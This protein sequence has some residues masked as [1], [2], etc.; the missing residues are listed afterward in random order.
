[1]KSQTGSGSPSRLSMFVFLAFL[2]LRVIFETRVSTFTGGELGGMT[3]DII[4]ELL[5]GS[6]LLLCSLSEATEQT[7]CSR[8]NKLLPSA[9]ACRIWLSPD[10]SP[11]AQSSPIKTAMPLR[12]AALAALPNICQRTL[13]GLYLEAYRK[14][15]QYR[16][17]EHLFHVPM[18][19]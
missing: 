15:S 16:C 9:I 11:I 13:V 3:S 12:F 19:R 6:M 2:F 7:S 8:F 18:H 10:L 4:G 1:M 17:R 14:L 5:D